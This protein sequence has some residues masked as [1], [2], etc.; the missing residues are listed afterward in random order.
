MEA[1]VPD[2]AAARLPSLSLP[3]LWLI[4]FAGVPYSNGTKSEESRL[5]PGCCRLESGVS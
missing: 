4:K 2:P 5:D 1:R 3:S